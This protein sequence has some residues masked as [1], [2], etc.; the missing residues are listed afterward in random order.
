MSDTKVLCSRV[1]SCEAPT[2]AISCNSDDFC[3]ILDTTFTSAST[4]I[5]CAAAFVSLSDFFLRRLLFIACA[6]E[7]LEFLS[8]T[9]LV[10]GSLVT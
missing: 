10:L 3:N 2:T 1:A 5:L 9:L 8:N 6:H 4:L 7:N